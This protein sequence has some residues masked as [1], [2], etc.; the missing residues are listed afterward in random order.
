MHI[1]TARMA[2]SCGFFAFLFLIF[3]N[4]EAE[5]ILPSAFGFLPIK[6]NLRFCCKDTRVLLQ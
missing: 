2:Y 1:K 6:G 5:G 3:R 4:K